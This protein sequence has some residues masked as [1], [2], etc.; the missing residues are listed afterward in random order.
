MVELAEDSPQASG[1]E[2]DVRVNEGAESE[3]DAGQGASPRL[4][5]E[6]RFGECGRI[7]SRSRTFCECKERNRERMFGKEKWKVVG[8]YKAIIRGKMRGTRGFE[9]NL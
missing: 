9:K 1:E 8:K 6:G 2:P 4:G 3:G 5:E 7:F